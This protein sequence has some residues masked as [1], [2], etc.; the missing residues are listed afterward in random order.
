[1]SEPKLSFSIDEGGH[2]LSVAVAGTFGKE[3][4]AGL[5]TWSE[6]IKA[7]VSK[8]CEKDGKRLNSLVDLT[9]LESY[10]SAAALGEMA[11]L[12]RDNARY[13][14][15]TATFGANELLLAAEEIAALI[16]HRDNFKA[17]KTKDEALAWLA[18]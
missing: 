14:R 15:K 8:A 18:E 4:M 5:S 11:K 1:M 9:G 10:T 2:L 6:E 13:I 16:A 17:F 12:M 7:A 3:D